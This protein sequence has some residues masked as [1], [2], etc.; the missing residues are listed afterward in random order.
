MKLPGD[1]PVAFSPDGRLLA[2]SLKSWVQKEGSKDGFSRELRTEVRIGEVETG[3]DRFAPVNLGGVYL[4]DITFSTDGARLLALFTISDNSGLGKQKLELHSLDTQTGKQLLPPVRFPDVN[5]PR[6]LTLAPTGTAVAAVVDQT[7]LLRVYEGRHGTLLQERFGKKDRPAQFGVDRLHLAA[8]AFSPDG[9]HLLAV[10]QEPNRPG[11]LRVLAVPPSHLETVYDSFPGPLT[12]LAI[13]PDGKQFA[14]AGLDGKAYLHT[15]GA[16]EKPAIISALPGPVAAVAFTPDG[17]SLGCA[18]GR[19]G[20]AGIVNLVPLTPGPPQPIAVNFKGAAH[21]LSLSPDGRL[22]AVSG[23]NAVV[24]VDRTTLRTVRGLLHEHPM[25]TVA[26]HPDSRQLASGGFGRIWIGDAVEGKTIRHLDIPALPSALAYSPDGSLLA[27]A[28]SDGVVRIWDVRMGKETARLQGH[29]GRAWCLAWDH[30]GKMLASGGGELEQ[31]GEIVLWEVATGRRLLEMAG[32]H[33]PVRG[34][35]FHPDGRLFSAG[36]DGTVKEWRPPGTSRRSTEPTALAARW[37]NDGK[38]L[39]LGLRDG[40]PLFVGDPKW[41]DYTVEVE[42]MATGGQGELNVLVRASGAG[43]NTRV[44]LGG[45]DNRFHGF[46]VARPGSPTLEL[47]PLSGRPGNAVPASTERMRWYTI[48][49]DVRGETA[50]VFLDG[51]SLMKTTALPQKQG[52]I[53]LNAIATSARFRNLK[54]TGPDGKTLLDKLPTV[55]AGPG[56]VTGP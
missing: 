48:R 53:G 20:R 1:G 47:L 14:A 41:T 6:L 43:Q 3:K 7:N 44:I 16:K 54:V 49:V 2:R 34:L 19:S 52:N 29:S 28:A 26:F 30:G 33:G 13:T 37:R 21:A 39:V 32:H 45:W 8:L 46:L 42:A 18:G 9:Q 22:L 27:A 12:A 51:K 50:E 35:T 23:D 40:F 10:T 36:W 25:L 24:V 11:S 31:P 55:S 4:R 15:L 56:D 38:E 17:K 5:M